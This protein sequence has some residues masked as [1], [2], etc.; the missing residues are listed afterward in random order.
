[1]NDVATRPVVG[2]GLMSRD[3]LS[4]SLNKMASS[5]VVKGGDFVFLRL[6]PDDGIWEYGQ[7]NTEVDK[8]GVWAVN[9]GSF[10][11]GYIAWHN[12]NVEDEVLVPIN[13]DL[14][15]RGTLA[16]V[17][18]P[19]GWEEQK[20]VQLVAV[21]GKDTGV[22]VDYKASTEGSK[23]FFLDLTNAIMAQMQ[24]PAIEEVI[25]LVK[26]GSKS[27]EAKKYGN[28]TIWNPLFTVVGW[29][30]PDDATPPS[31]AEQ[32]GTAQTG[33]EREKQTVTV[34]AA[35]VGTISAA[36]LAGQPAANAG[37]PENAD[38]PRRR[39]RRG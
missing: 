37:Q 31:T 2:V 33:S 36:D 26:L 18:A 25:P 22:L 34:T 11:H 30:K 35:D 4:A 27:Y 10:R 9:I 7:E 12:S 20:A 5:I 13:R 23:R 28:K 39:N 6:S 1:M 29:R 17:K 14:P 19:K 16:V 8:D 21:S 24:N 15:D 32:K 38:I 3:V